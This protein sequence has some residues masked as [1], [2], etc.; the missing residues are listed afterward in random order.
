MI[1]PKSS[2]LL[3]LGTCASRRLRWVHADVCDSARAL[4]LSHLCGPAAGLVLAEALGGVALLGSE[5]TEAD[6][7]LS[8]RMRV[9]G[10]VEG[11]LVETARDGGLRGYP[12][13]KVLNE[14]DDQEEVVTAPALGD[15]AEVQVIRSVPGRIVSYASL[16]VRPATVAATIERYYADSLQRQVFVALSATTYE[17]YIDLARALLIECPKDG[18]RREYDRLRRRADD[19]S[20]LEALEAAPGVSALFEE[21]GLRDV[22]MEMPRP[23][24]F[25]CRCSAARAETTLSALSPE[26]FEE[27]AAAGRP[28]EIHCHMCGKSYTVPAARLAALRAARGSAGHEERGSEC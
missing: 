27:M 2:D 9:S 28:A 5:L 19:G 23:L 6:E 10:P 7:S 22:R 17:G 11:V 18:H 20:L 26:E 4:G 1:V 13:M 25:A 3:H 14:L 12:H 21:L 8:L 16:E 24:R 15:R